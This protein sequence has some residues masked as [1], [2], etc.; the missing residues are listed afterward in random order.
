[1]KSKLLSVLIMIVLFVSIFN[2]KVNAVDPFSFEKASI[3]VG[4]NSSKYVNYS[5]GSGTITWSSSD[6]TVA[7]VDNGSIK[8]L[9]IGQTT[10][11]A[12][13]GSETAT[14]TAKVVYGSI[15][16]GANGTSSTSRVSLVLNEHN[17]ETLVATV[18]DGKNEVVSNANVSWSSSDSSV[19][20]VS[21]TGVINAVKTGSAT[22]TAEAAGVSDTCEVIVSNQEEL[23]EFR[24]AKY[25][26][27]LDGTIETLKI[28]GVTPKDTAGNGYYYMITP[29]NTKPELV[30]KRG[31]IDFDAMND[32]IEYLSVNAE[33]NYLYSRNISKY[34]ELNQDL[35]IWVI[36]TSKLDESYVDEDGNYTFYT[37]KFV[38]EGKK[39]DRAELPPL[40]LILQSMCIG[41][42]NSTSTGDTENYTYIRFNFPSVTENRKFTLKIGRVSDNSILNKIKNNDYTGITDLLSYAKNNEAVYSKKLTTT[43]NAYFRA[44]D[45]LFDGRSLLK[46]KDYYFVYAEFDDE[47]G[48]YYPI[49]G[50]TLGQAWFSSS[51][52]SWDIYAYTSSDFNWEN[53]SSTYTPS[54]P[55]TAPGILPQT[56]TNAVIVGTIIIAISTIGFCCYK[57]YNK[58]HG[59]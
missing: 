30:L 39:I 33:D 11:T 2:V 24:N 58:Y 59:I 51:S 14:C 35:Y 54:D 9:K 8:G 48:K 53:L 28:T 31:Q 49:E 38:V 50:V 7:T 18:K 56:G 25:E 15:Q 46:N 26:L 22:I 3:D 40:N 47:N 57:K 43:S 21:N 44:D 10:I 17:S 12:T 27:T 5:G 52:S 16:I 45:A 29:N 20:T 42:Y 37:T 41:H 6:P 34:A 4:L 13:R 32:K 19:V 1:M 23:T 55:T 36:Q